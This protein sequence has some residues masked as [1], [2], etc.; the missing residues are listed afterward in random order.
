MLLRRLR[1]ACKSA[2]GALRSSPMRSLLTTLGIT[3]GTAAIIAVVALVGSAK[4]FVSEAISSLGENLVVVWSQPHEGSDRYEALTLGDMKALEALPEVQRVAPGVSSKGKLHW[5]GQL[6]EVGIKGVNP[7]YRRIRTSK[8]A[9]GRYVTEADIRSQARVAVIDNVLATTVLAGTDPLGQP[10]RVDDT[11]YTVVGVLEKEAVESL[12]N[13]RREGR[14][15][16]PLSWLAHLTGERQ[17]N[18]LLLKG[19][20]GSSGEALGKKASDFLAARH[21]WRCHM[22]F[23]A[24]DTIVAKVEQVGLILTLV[25]GAVA[26]VAL[27]VGGVGVMNVMLMAVV[28]RTRE[29]GIRK[30]LGA[31]DRDLL[32]QFLLEATVLSLAGGALGIALGIGIGWVGVVALGALSGVAGTL[33]IPGMAIG[34]ALSSTA[35]VGLVFGTIPAYR[36][37]R[38]DPIVCL[39]YE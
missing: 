17:Y 18:Y 9:S 15:F 19:S 1:E 32:L 4:G 16:V 7:D 31:T 29:I 5:K 8:L 23:E 2:W 39:R 11:L 36:A 35:G 33:T 25:M 24:L 12:G 10:I 38:L 13:G 6:E 37:A 34:L 30:A 22:G 14:I 3:I 27:V 21:G 26:A 28:E 20:P